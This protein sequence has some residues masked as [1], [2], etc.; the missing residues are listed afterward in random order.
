MYRKTVHNFTSDLFISYMPRTP[1]AFVQT[2]SPFSPPS[3]FTSSAYYLLKF[4]APGSD[5]FFCIKRRCI[6]PWPWAMSLRLYICTAVMLQNDKSHLNYDFLGEKK[7]PIIRAILL[8]TH[9]RLIKK[10]ST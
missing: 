9:A 1:K 4:A 7:S 2:V 6:C 8:F 3:Q 10:P 5:I